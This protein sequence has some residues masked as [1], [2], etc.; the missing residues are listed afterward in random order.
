MNGKRSQLAALSIFGKPCVA[1]IFVEMLPHQK[2]GLL[3]KLGCLFGRCETKILQQ[4]D[5]QELKRNYCINN[6]FG[7]TVV[8]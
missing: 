5:N 2:Q 1:I 7:A 6:H 4:H 3:K 8:L